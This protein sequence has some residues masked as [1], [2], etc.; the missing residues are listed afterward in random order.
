MTRSKFG[1]DQKSFL[2]RSPFWAVIPVGGIPMIT[3]ERF[4]AQLEDIGDK[5]S[6]KLTMINSI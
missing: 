6:F 4:K 2:V 1:S 5:V 3:I